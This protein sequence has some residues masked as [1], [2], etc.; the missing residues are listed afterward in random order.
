MM[1]ILAQTAG[2]AALTG[3]IVGIVLVVMRL[4]EKFAPILRRDPN[5]DGRP[6]F[7]A[8]DRHMLGRMHDICTAKDARGMP[9]CYTP[10][11][12]T[13]TLRRQVQILERVEGILMRLAETSI[14]QADACAD[15][16]HQ[17]DAL[18][19]RTEVK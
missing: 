19:Q 6:T 8:T 14:R 7:R 13:E 12:L 9:L 3:G 4:V 10:P 11:E 5:E 15:H 18:R 1:A 16:V 2:D 17:F